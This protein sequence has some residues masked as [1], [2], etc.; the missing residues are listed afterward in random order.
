MGFDF[1]GVKTNL[2][3]IKNYL[4]ANGVKLSDDDTKSLE[5]IFTQADTSTHE[6]SNEEYNNGEL[7][8]EEQM[9]FKNLLPQNLENLK[10]KI[11]S[12]FNGI[13]EK[14][15]EKAIKSEAT[16]PTDAIKDERPK[17]VPIKNKSIKHT[18]SYTKEDIYLI[19]IDQCIKRTPELKNIQPASKR[20]NTAT[21]KYPA[22]INKNSQKAKQVTDMVMRLCTEYDVPELVPVITSMLGTETGG[23]NFSA[24]VLNKNGK[25]GCPKGSMQTD[26]NTIGAL[27]KD[28]KSSDVQFI[29]K[30]KSKYKTPNALYRAIQTDV[31]LGLQVGI[32]I[33]KQKLRANGGSIKAA[34]RAYCGG[35]YRYDYPTKVPDKIDV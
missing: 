31:E 21:K 27:Y 13:N 34:V 22:L 28:E 11:S 33:F 17:F 10:N 15:L 5:S 19:A 14:I 9:V 4:D 25:F 26:L 30:L 24:K 6:E 3:G 23:F 8:L 2:E 35:S 16:E 29:K 12:F 18:I 7:D 20:I 1:T 32:L